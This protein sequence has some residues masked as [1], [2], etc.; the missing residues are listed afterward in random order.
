MRQYKW[1]LLALVMAFVVTL[2]SGTRGHTPISS[3]WN[4]NEHL[5]PIFRDQCGSCHIEG[6]I[7]PMSLMTY[8]DAFPWTQSI[9]E[10]ILGLRMPPWQAEDGFGMF[11]NGH[12]L[13]AHD[14]DMILEW[15][16][17]GYPQGPRD[18]APPAPEL[19]AEWT[20]GAPAMTL[21]MPEAFEIDAGTRE[22]IR[23]FVL[24]SD[25]G[26]DRTISAVDLQPG[27][28]AVVRSA[29]VFVDTE[30]AAR[31]LDDADS[32]PGFADPEDGAFP[33]APPVAV[34]IPGQA[35]VR[36]QGM[37]FP[38]PNGSDVVLRVQYKKTWITEGQA[39]TDQS[40]VGL[41]FSEGGA[42]S[43]DSMIVTSPATVSGLEVTFSHD[44]GTDVTLLSLIPEVDI[45]SSAIQVEAVK[46]DGSRIPMLWLREPDSGWTTRFWFDAPVSLP[47]GSRLEFTAILDPGAERRP[48]TS[49]LGAAAAVPI[50]FAV[51]YIDGVA[52]AN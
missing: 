22:L 31:A 3:R 21:E 41:Y 45:E 47:Q 40:R 52:P 1:W 30:G 42:D 32:A 17:G 28:R 13:S 4:Y 51:D 12:A 2:G 10:E 14:M 23:Y 27:A 36:T 9:R 49:L 25:T 34:W 18:Q 15:S 11:R 44:I 16:S 7:A 6:G 5:F 33:S 35:P 39:F 24:A 38:L 50:R 37:G 19:S 43:I 29:A 48:A 8:Q 46:P 26:E 20:L